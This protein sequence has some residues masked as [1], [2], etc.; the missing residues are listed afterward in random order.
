M[1]NVPQLDRSTQP[2]V[3]TGELESATRA[4]QAAAP[5]VIRDFLG[6]LYRRWP[7]IAGVI[8]AG[9][10]SALLYNRMATP[11]F[12]ATATLQIDA[13]PNVL[14]AER[15]M[16]ELRD[17]M[18]EYLPTQIGILASGDLAQL[19]HDDLMRSSHGSDTQ[20]PSAADILG[21][22]AVENP[23]DTRL[24]TIAFQSADPVMAANVA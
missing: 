9:L 19:A 3:D 18:K 7:M 17:W 6:V 10:L 15:P 16:L 14:G 22:R 2:D 4:I 12:V 13:Y 1:S 5:L 23:K 20:V 11:V 21:G 24:A 8:A